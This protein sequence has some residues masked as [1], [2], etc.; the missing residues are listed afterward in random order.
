MA[1]ELVLASR[2]RAFSVHLLISVLVALSVAVLVFWIWYPAPLQIAVGVTDV[3]LLLL[4]VDVIVGPC[5]TFLV[6]DTGKKALAFDLAVVA[7][8]QLAALTYGLLAVA[9]GRPVWLV[10]NA[11][12]FDVVRRIDVDER[13][14]ANAL[15]EYRRIPWLGPRWVAAVRPNSAEERTTILFEA[16]TAGVDLAQRPQYYASIDEMAL[17]IVARAKPLHE[18]S[19]YNAPADVENT[20]EQWPQADAWLPIASNAEDMVVLVQRSSGRIVAIT[21]LRP[22]I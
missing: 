14:L 9:D 11:D 22:W 15:P 3:F 6:F 2:F 19:Q 17:E 5:L 8:L 16:L 20:I 1:C 12:R 21:D 4:M 10:F 13:S 18:L 7:M